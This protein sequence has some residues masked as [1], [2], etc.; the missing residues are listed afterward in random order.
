MIV[1]S[2]PVVMQSQEHPLVGKVRSSLNVPGGN[3]LDQS[4]MEVLRG[5]QRGNGLEPHGE[6][7]E[8]TL[9][10]FGLSVY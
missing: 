6:L 8:V 3:V 4:L 9:G 10:L 7:D 5:V 2:V 1:S